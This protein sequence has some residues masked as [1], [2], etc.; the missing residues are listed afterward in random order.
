M[1]F[2]CQLAC[3]PRHQRL[4]YE[5]CAY[6]KSGSP[7]EG[8]FPPS[9]ARSRRSS[10]TGGS[11]V[12]NGVRISWRHGVPT[13][14][15]GWI[16]LTAVGIALTWPPVRTNGHYV[17]VYGLLG[18]LVCP[19]VWIP[20]LIAK[21]APLVGCHPASSAHIFQAIVNIGPIAHRDLPARRAAGELV[22]GLRVASPEL[23]SGKPPSARSAVRR[24]GWANPSLRS[25][26]RCGAPTTP[27]SSG[28]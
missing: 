22:P 25:P 26:K 9:P 14:A 2:I 3:L 24:A 18:Q 19:T 17:A 20:A 23:P 6:I 7:S 4:F 27:E 21:L 1:G 12:Q 11:G 15:Q 5:L 8:L 16:Y 13:G 28:S 10:C